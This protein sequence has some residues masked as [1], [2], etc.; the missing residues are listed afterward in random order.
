M[1]VIR[2]ENST[3]MLGGKLWRVSQSWLFN[4]YDEDEEES[5]ISK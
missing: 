1:V 2:H 5:I 3:S 4:V